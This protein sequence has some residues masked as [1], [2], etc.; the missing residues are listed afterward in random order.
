MDI[1][2]KIFGNRDKVKIM[3]LFLFNFDEVFETAEIARRSNSSLQSVNREIQNL[4]RA[5]LVKKKIFTKVTPS[6]NKVKRT[7]WVL[8]KQFLFLKPLKNFLINQE[9]ISEKEIQKRLSA[10]GIVKLVAIS[11]IFIQNE[12][13]RVD[14][15]LVADRLNETILKKVIRN[16]EAEIGK[17]I[18]YAAFELDEF[19]YRLGMRDKLIRDIFDYPHRKIINKINL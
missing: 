11:G 3:R 5:E 4:S 2:E 15:L 10:V 1:L 19:K 17:E 8:N 14:L 13:V 16:M 12:E 7:G 9:T 6:G 18:R